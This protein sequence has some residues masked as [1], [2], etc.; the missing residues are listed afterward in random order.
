M[1]PLVSLS[2]RLVLVGRGLHLSGEGV[3]RSGQV[4]VKSADVTSW[5]GRRG[6]S[7]GFVP[8]LVRWRVRETEREEPKSIFASGISGTRRSHLEQVVLQETS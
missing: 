6:P 2:K 1:V 7:R 3:A 5:Q 8:P 4:T